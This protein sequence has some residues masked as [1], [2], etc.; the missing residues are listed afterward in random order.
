MTT[1]IDD[2]DD[3]N[4]NDDSDDDCDDGDKGHHPPKKRDFLGIFPKC[5]PPLSPFLEPLFPKKKYGLICILGP[6]EHFWSSSKCSL[7]GNYSEIYFW[8]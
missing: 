7:F 1:I 3:N 2:H 8:E 4:Y 5:Q 6:L